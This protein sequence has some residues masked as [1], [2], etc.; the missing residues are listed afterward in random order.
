MKATQGLLTWFLIFTIS[1]PAVS[2]A[3]PPQAGKPIGSGPEMGPGNLNSAYGS[4]AG[5]VFNHDNAQTKG[6]KDSVQSAID[7]AAKAIK[8]CNDKYPQRSFTD[9]TLKALQALGGSAASGGG[10]P[11]S[12]GLGGDPT[13]STGL[14]SLGGGGA[15]AQS[16]GLGGYGGI[17]GGDASQVQVNC[18]NFMSIMSRERDQFLAAFKT[19][20]SSKLYPQSR[21][22]TCVTGG[23][24]GDSYSSDPS[25]TPP[26]LDS[27]CVDGIFAVAVSQ[28]SDACAQSRQNGQTAQ[29]A[30][31]VVT[32]IGGLLSDVDAN[33]KGAQAE[34]VRGQ[35]VGAIGSF[36]SVMPGVDTL[37]S[38]GVSMF[39]G[40]LGSLFKHT[41][42]PEKLAKNLSDANKRLSKACLLVQGFDV[43]P[44]CHEPTPAG[45]GGTGEAPHGSSD[46]APTG[47]KPNLQAAKT[48]ID[49]QLKSVVDA[50][51]ASGATSDATLKAKLWNNA[52]VREAVKNLV[53]TFSRP[54][55]FPIET[56]PGHVEIQQ[57]SLTD[58]L[59]RLT[60]MPA[61]KN[62]DDALSVKPLV[63]AVRSYQAAPGKDHLLD[64]VKAFSAT[65]DLDPSG[66]TQPVLVAPLMQAYLDQQSI[67]G[68]MA[69]FRN[70]GDGQELAQVQHELEAIHHSL[71]DA[72]ASE[73]TGTY[74][75]MKGLLDVSAQ[76]LQVKFKNE[77]ERTQAD[78]SRELPYTQF[79]SIRTVF[80]NCLLLTPSLYWN[81]HSHQMD[82]R[83]GKENWTRECQAFSCM[84]GGDAPKCS[85]GA[86]PDRCMKELMKESS[87]VGKNLY[88]VKVG[89]LRAVLQN[90]KKVCGRTVDQV[91][92]CFRD[93]S[94]C[95]A[96]SAPASPGEG[97]GAN[98][99]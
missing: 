38:L 84:L 49:S 54:R 11:Y 52:G 83:A 4:T 29:A 64:L 95:P 35:V 96:G 3:T 62:S 39:S 25:T 18:D 17:G 30:S 88:D 22:S 68:F 12:S 34:Q 20:L 98:G 33:C 42:S 9:A 69:G 63:D 51:N 45:S 66:R 8:A 93:P 5:C 56:A 59:D 23:K 87:C 1:T 58:F 50:V 71:V 81:S 26:V 74:V 40:I 76:D 67:K 82:S 78:L 13:S 15:Y 89:Q 53:Q 94:H 92:A 77:R 14:S 99:G 32:L 36:F 41:N 72:A 97:G 19:G 48:D 60:Q 24:G 31:D 2:W 79:A 47:P 10:S 55:P 73:E 85:E 90:E 7:D 57:L 61:L 86:S 6:F 16:Y 37:G 70:A 44:E 28:K 46:P 91:V 43:M 65:G 27:A 75:Y 21:Y 80:D